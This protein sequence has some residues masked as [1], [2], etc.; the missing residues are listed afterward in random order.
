VFDPLAVALILITN[1]V[2][3]IESGQY[4]PEPEVAKRKKESIL[5]KIKNYKRKIKEV[6][7]VEVQT[8]PDGDVT[9]FKSPGVFTREFDNFPIEPIVDN[10]EP[11]LEDIPEPELEV[12]EVVPH[13]AEQPTYGKIK[14]DDIKEVK[15]RNRGF[16]VN[17]PYPKGNTIQR[18]SGVNEKPLNKNNNYFRR[19]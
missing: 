4:I 8:K 9:E 16:S 1:R 13:S 7:N 14:L 10:E 6:K 18:V 19:S 2:F 15:D 12:E 5:A 3:Q 11:I 17:V